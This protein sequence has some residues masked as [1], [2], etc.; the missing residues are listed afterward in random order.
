[1]KTR[2]ALRAQTTE[3]TVNV[4]TLKAKLSQYLKRAKNGERIV[5]YDRAEPIAELSAPSKSENAFERLA[6]E[7]VCRLGTQD[8]GTLRIPPASANEKKLD[9][10]KLLEEVRK[11]SL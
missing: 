5:I 7:G 2:A 9:W 4:S 10:V 8:W 3:R 1:M 11:D 6:R